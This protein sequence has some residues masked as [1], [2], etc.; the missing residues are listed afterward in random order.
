VINVIGCFLI[1]V[2]M[3]C[4]TGDLGLVLTTGFCGGYSTLSAMTVD[5]VKLLEGPDKQLAVKNVLYQ[6]VFPFM[7]AIVGAYLPLMVAGQV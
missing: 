4:F 5:T 3:A 1:G 7:A 6:M 2:F